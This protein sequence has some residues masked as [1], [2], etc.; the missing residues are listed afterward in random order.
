M[1]IFRNQNIQEMI[2]IAE[3]DHETAKNDF[4]IFLILL[5]RP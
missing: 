1:E 3:K 2:A 4:K 5:K